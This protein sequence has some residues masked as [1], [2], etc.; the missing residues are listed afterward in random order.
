MSDVAIS[1]EGLG[2]RYRIAHQRDPYGR[3][4]ESL[5]SAF[6]APLDR[7]R[8][9]PRQTAEWFWAL[10]DVSF[11]LRHGGVLG[12]I[13][14]N[15]A[16]KSTLLKILSRITEPTT[17][18]AQL[19]GRVGSLLEVGTGFHPELTGRENIL[20]S[21]AVLGIRRRE[22]ERQFDAIVSFSGVG[23]FLDTPVKRYSSGMQVR[24]GFSVAAHLQSDILI[25]DEVLAVGDAEFQKRCLAKLEDASKHGRTV[26]F[27]SHNMA[28]VEALCSS[29]LLLDRGG[30]AMTGPVK[31]VIYAYLAQSEKLLEFD[32][33][34]R[35]DREGTGEMHVVSVRSDVR[36]GAASTLSLGYRARTRISNV[37]ISVGVF[38]IRGEGALHLSSA[39]SGDS[40]ADVP[41]EGDL[42]CQ[43]DV[44]GLLPGRYTLNL[45]CT[46]NGVLA[47]WV[48]DAAVIEVSEGDFYGT[49]RLPP[50][51]YGSVAVPY[52][53]S[54]KT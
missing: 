32:L 45:Y 2:K 40:F 9:K 38:N 24:L 17:G 26:L 48:V 30:V 13:G 10:R 20:L 27:V 37:E 31:D 6:Q 39:T 42:V 4:T 34:D 35:P 19:E 14:R 46:V 16:G 29:G 52:R 28:A 11:E 53:W 21:G 44:A 54:L 12:V 5:A 15:G 47:D 36:T 43:F 7:M 23:R 22:L 50:S 25:V 33:A 41:A 1:V 49:G 3:L 51:G 18:T 8:G